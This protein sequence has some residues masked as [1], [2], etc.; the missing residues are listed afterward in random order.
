MHE[1]LDRLTDLAT[2]D[3][4]ME[5][6]RDAKKVFFRATG[7]VFEEDDF[8]ESRMR[9]FME[10]YLFDYKGPDSTVPD[11]VDRVLEDYKNEL[12]ASETDTF[13]KFR[14]GVHGLFELK[15]HRGE[16]FTLLN[17]WDKKKYDVRERRA[18]HGVAKKDLFEARLLPFEDHLYFANA[19]VFHPK[20]VKK[21][22]VAFLK[23]A[24]DSDERLVPTLHR[25]AHLRLKFDRYRGMDAR[26][27]YSAETM[28]Q[29][30]MR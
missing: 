5:R 27:I 14:R 29:W 19:F 10:F 16:F 8:Y 15:K 12:S 20:E 23:E 28:E 7:E 13:I 9:G 25:L 3:R 22:I 18:M 26:K 21:F 2:A 1:Y 4:Y 17:L 30:R 11:T 24:K 6:I